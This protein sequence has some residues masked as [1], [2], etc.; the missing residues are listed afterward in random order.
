MIKEVGIEA[1]MPKL[2]DP[3]G[4]F[5]WK[6]SY[7][8]VQDLQGKMLAHPNPKLV[9]K[10]FNGMKDVNGKMFNSEMTEIAKNAGEGW[11][12]YM[13]PK[14]NEHNPIGQKCVYLAGAWPGDH[15][16]GGNL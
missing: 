11:V 9:G 13:W 8:F 15:G 10:S 3:K 1:A 2:Q 7:V 4:P 16:R 14:P 6:D 5:V 12:S